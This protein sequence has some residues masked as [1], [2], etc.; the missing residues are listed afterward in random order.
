MLQSVKRFVMQMDASGAQLP[1][2]DAAERLSATLVADFDLESKAHL[3]GR[4]VAPKQRSKAQ[5]ASQNPNSLVAFQAMHRLC[6]RTLSFQHQPKCSNDNSNAH[7]TDATSV[8]RS[9]CRASVWRSGNVA[10]DVT[11]RDPRDEGGGCRCRLVGFSR[12]WQ[13]QVLAF[14]RYELRW[15]RAHYHIVAKARRAAAKVAFSA[16]LSPCLPDLGKLHVFPCCM[17]RKWNGSNF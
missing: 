5:S 10:L 8:W 12:Y 17:F 6:Q 9:C 11:S 15:R 14:M 4:R 16:P 1:S 3:R 13:Q 2:R 7:L